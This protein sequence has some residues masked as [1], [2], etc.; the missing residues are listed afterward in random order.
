MKVVKQ[1]QMKINITKLS[2]H[3]VSYKYLNIYCFFQ[4]N[5]SS[6]N[7]K[8]FH[9]STVSNTNNNS[10]SSI[11]PAKQNNF[12]GHNKNNNLFNHKIPSFKP[13]TSLKKYPFNEKMNLYKK[14]NESLHYI[15]STSYKFP[16]DLYEVELI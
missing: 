7:K 1:N 11:K 13:K 6:V 12:F 9:S 14:K 5:A 16:L 10:I 4:K 8:I 2:S 15:N 3:N